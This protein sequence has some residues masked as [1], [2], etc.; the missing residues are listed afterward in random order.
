MRR[1]S[2]L[3][4]GGVKLFVILVRLGEMESSVSRMPIMESIESFVIVSV[5]KDVKKEG[6]RV[7]RRQHLMPIRSMEN[8][9]IIYLRNLRGARLFI[10]SLT[11]G[12][13]V[14]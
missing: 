7:T 11:I 8:S 2:I 12:D 6:H 10:T 13:V 5:A 1:S 9:D 3:L 4:D 14:L